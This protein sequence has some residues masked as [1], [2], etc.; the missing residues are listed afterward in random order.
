MLHTPIHIEHSE[1]LKRELRA[2]AAP[3]SAAK[4]TVGD[5]LLHLAKLGEKLKVTGPTD[6]SSRIDDYL[7]DGK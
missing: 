2:H 3:Q 4:E 6:L 1:Q 7:Y 5:A